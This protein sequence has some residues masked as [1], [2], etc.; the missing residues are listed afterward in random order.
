MFLRL[1]ICGLVCGEERLLLHQGEIGAAWIGCSCKLSIF[2][3][4]IIFSL[5]QISSLQ[6]HWT[7]VLVIQFWRMH[8]LKR[9]N[10]FVN[11]NALFLS[12][13]QRCLPRLEI[14]PTYWT[15]KS[16]SLSWPPGWRW[17]CSM[18]RVSTKMTS[19][20][21]LIHLSCNFFS[22]NRLKYYPKPNYFF[23]YN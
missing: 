9:I 14:V 11:L 16:S 19:R 3:P 2:F 23:N 7:L 22:L 21:R 4:Y 1:F 10:D 5:K 20:I 12:R 6:I 15:T 17:Q 8:V 13:C 18:P